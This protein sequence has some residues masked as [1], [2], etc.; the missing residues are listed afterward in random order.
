MR[1]MIKN[2]TFLSLLFLGLTAPAHA[3]PEASIKEDYYSKIVPFSA[4]GERFPFKT[5]DGLALKGVRFL[6]PNSIGTIVVV[7]GRTETWLKYGEVFYDLFQAGYSIYS[8]DQRGQG[9][10]PHLSPL[11]PQI[12][13]V[14]KFDSYVDDLN[15]FVNEVVVPNVK[16]EEKLFLLSH[17]MG[18]AVSAAY[19]SQGKV[20]FRK[21][22]LSSPMLQINTAP[23]KEFEARAIV[24]AFTAVG[25]GTHY[26]IGKT[27]WDPSLTYDKDTLT[28][29]E[30]RYWL[31]KQVFLDNPT[32]ILGGASNKWISQSI[33][34]THRIRKKMDGIKT[35]F[36][37]FQAGNDQIVSPEGQNEGCKKA[38]EYCTQI[39][40]PGSQHEIMME[41]DNIRNDFFTH[42]YKFF[43]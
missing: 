18:G 30:N 4:T 28:G 3:L 5:H 24:G 37:L 33:T 14:K 17:S 38:G 34:A 41:K 32:T 42:L 39:I 7:N 12:G 16:P 8:Y 43:Q 40:E 2:L 29:C 23:Y 35:P 10:S 25:L 27:D 19:L 15:V 1:R 31:Y 22:I 36:L 20:P 9:L 13:Y 11:N 26:A 21:A 6:N